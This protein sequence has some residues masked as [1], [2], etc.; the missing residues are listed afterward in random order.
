MRAAGRADA[1]L[2]VFLTGSAVMGVSAVIFPLMPTGVGSAAVLAVVNFPAAFPFGVTAA[3]L[4]VVT[5]P[6]LRAQVAALFLLVTNLVGL[7][8]GPWLVGV[9]TDRVFH[10]EQ[11][12]GMALALLAGS[13]HVAAIAC[14]GMARARFRAAAQV[15]WN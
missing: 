7:A 4:A 9:L 3:A 14:M 15:S 1:D 6:H 13:G 10:D 12:I 2:I 11:A 5:P 8:L